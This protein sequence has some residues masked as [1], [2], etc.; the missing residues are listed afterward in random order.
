MHNLNGDW[1]GTISGT[2]NGDVFIEIK[3]S[4]N[5]VVGKVRIHDRILGVTVYLLTGKI[6]GDQLLLSLVP[7]TRQQATKVN[8]LVNNQAV[9]VQIPTIELGNVSVKAALTNPALK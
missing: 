7:E 3:Q 4:G 6:D 1:V 8:I 9:P 5:A 2:N